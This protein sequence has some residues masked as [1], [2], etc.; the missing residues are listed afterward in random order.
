MSVHLRLSQ[1]QIY[2]NYLETL[3]NLNKNDKAKIITSNLRTVREK[4][5][6]K[7]IL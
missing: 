3:V 4:F 1:P 7:Q 2:S 5:L 6:K